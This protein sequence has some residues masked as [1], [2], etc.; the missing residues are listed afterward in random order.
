MIKSADI[1]SRGIDIS[2]SERFDRL[3]HRAYLRSRYL[4][5]NND[6]SRVSM[7]E[8]HVQSLGL[9]PLSWYQGDD[10][11]RET[12]ISASGRTT[13]TPGTPPYSIKCRINADHGRC[14][15]S[16]FLSPFKNSS[17]QL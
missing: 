8:T 5:N 7:R 11:A 15:S 14:L 17:I 16:L 3:S 9:D 6:I 10:R 4:R 2:R 12:E 13:R 1:S